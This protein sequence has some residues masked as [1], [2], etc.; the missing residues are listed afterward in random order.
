VLVPEISVYK[1][2]YNSAIPIFVENMIFDVGA[3]FI[4]AHSSNRFDSRAGI[5]P[6]PTK[7]DIIQTEK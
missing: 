5:N 1:I 3:G 2:A 6:A 4:P 7:K